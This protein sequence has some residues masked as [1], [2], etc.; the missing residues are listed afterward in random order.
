MT[1]GC[2]DPRVFGHRCEPYRPYWGGDPWACPPH[3][4]IVPLYRKTGGKTEL[5]AFS[6]TT[7]QTPGGSWQFTQ[8]P[9]P[10]VFTRRRRES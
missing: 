6:V 10:N 7:A 9:L 4:R 5:L 8:I 2:H 1:C 3:A